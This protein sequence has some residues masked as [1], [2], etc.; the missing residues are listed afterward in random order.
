M[1][2]A[3]AASVYFDLLPADKAIHRRLRQ[4]FRGAGYQ[5]GDGFELTGDQSPR[6]PQLEALIKAAHAGL[7]AT[8]SVGRARPPGPKQGRTVPPV[9]DWSAAVAWVGPDLVPVRRTHR[10]TRATVFARCTV[11]IDLARAKGLGVKEVRECKAKGLLEFAPARGG[12]RRATPRV[13]AAHWTGFDR[14][15]WSLRLVRQGKGEFM[16]LFVGDTFAEQQEALP[17]LLERWPIERVELVA[18]LPW[19]DGTFARRALG[20][21]SRF[22][23]TTRTNRRLT[24]TPD[25]S[26]WFLMAIRCRIG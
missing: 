22:Y 1:I 17:E 20:E 25:I 11:A 3:V 15:A 12:P 23:P 24:T 5:D 18:A 9:G 2:A 21:R 16:S 8:A 10:L 14:R 13:V 4:L 6:L 26:H 19:E 7:G